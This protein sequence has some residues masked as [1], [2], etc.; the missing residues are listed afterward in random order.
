M[1]RS[2]VI[3]A[4]SLALAAVGLSGCGFTPLY[5]APGVTPG[6]SAIAVDQPQGRLGFLIREQLED[7][8]AHQA[9]DK[10]QW[11][12]AVK[13]DE[14]RSS[15]GVRVDNVAD[16]FQ[17]RVDANYSLNDATTGRRV[18]GGSVRVAVTYANPNQPYAAIAGDQEGQER[19]AAEAARQIQ[20]QLATWIA[21]QRK[22]GD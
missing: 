11:R 19:A 17:Y 14:S 16:R 7:A 22:V 1:R 3:F 6:L 18:Y 21:G 13:L 15:L 10:P 8:F 12:L 9:V 2:A 4:A 20:M 5:A